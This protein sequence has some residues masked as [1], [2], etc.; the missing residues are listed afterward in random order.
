MSP[1]LRARL[2]EESVSKMAQGKG[3]RIGRN[4]PRQGFTEN[5]LCLGDDLLTYGLSCKQS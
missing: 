3:R 4:T 2:D 5:K 1:S